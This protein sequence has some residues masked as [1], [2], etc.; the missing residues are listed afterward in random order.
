VTEQH[1]SI[2]EVLALL[3]DEF[4]DITISKI[5]FLESQGLVDPERTPSGYRRFYERDIERLRWIL[6]QQREHYLP[7]KVIKDRLEVLGG[8]EVPADPPAAAHDASSPAGAPVPPAGPPTGR[9]AG[10]GVAGT[11]ATAGGGVDDRGTRPTVPPDATVD[12]TT[13]PPRVLPEPTIFAAR[14]RSEAAAPAVPAPPAAPSADAPGAPGAPAVPAAPAVFRPQARGEDL[15]AISLTAE[16]LAEST[17]MRVA[18]LQE[19][20]RFGLLR[21]RMVGNTAIYDGDALVIAR[22]VAGFRAH[23]I[24]ARHLRMMKVAADREAALFE[25]VVLPLARQRNAEA[26]RRLQDTLTDLA[27]LTDSLHSLLLRDALRDLG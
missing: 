13:Q 20:E 11:T 26:R 5:R 21:H 23:G 24:E 14:P 1:R 2:G 8:D 10:G 16:E 4:P 19:L 9:G 7:L 22:L 15:T 3:R 18:E 27:R 25:Q 17:G 12:L 6:R